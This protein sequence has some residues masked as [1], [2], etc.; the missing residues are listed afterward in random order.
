MS[1]GHEMW[2]QAV[3][4]LEN[5]SLGALLLV[6]SGHESWSFG[7]NMSENVSSGSQ[8]LVRRSGHERGSQADTNIENASLGT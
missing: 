8:L 2:S 7:V 4:V 3:K 5:V 1:S 6:R